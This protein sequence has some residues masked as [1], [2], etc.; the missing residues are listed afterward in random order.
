LKNKKILFLLIL[1]FN[2]FTVNFSAQKESVKIDPVP[3]QIRT[4]DKNY[5]EKYLSSSDFDYTE[6]GPSLLA[7]IRQWMISK[8][9]EFFN[10]SDA[11]AAEIFK[12]VKLIFYIVVLL[13]VIYILIKIFLN[14]E[15]RWIFKKNSGSGQTEYTSIVENISEVDFKGLIR[16]AVS[17]ADYRLAIRYY[18]LWLLKGLDKS[19]LIRYDVEKT[20]FDYQQELLQ[21]DFSE[22]FKRAS[23]YYSYIWYGEFFIGEKEFETTSAVYNKLL[24]RIKDV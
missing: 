18:Y 19:G 12:T 7:R 8:I 1:W 14:K 9:M 11:D 23:Y 21:S 16:K 10:T 4:L 20:N 17:E 2:F 15:V 5:K 3:A 22:D 13:G 24:N 6:K